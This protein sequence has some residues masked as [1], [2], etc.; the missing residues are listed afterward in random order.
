MAERS[1]GL[2]PLSATDLVGDRASLLV[3][4]AMGLKKAQEGVVAGPKPGPIAVNPA[5]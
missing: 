5:A 1:L 3:E 2:R 4:G